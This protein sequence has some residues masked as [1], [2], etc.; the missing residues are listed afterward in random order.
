M[1]V[2]QEVSH[3]L[4]DG[5]RYPQA[6]TRLYGRDDVSEIEP[7]YLTTRWASLADH[8]PILVRLNGAGLLDELDAD[9]DLPRALS[10]LQSDA[11]S[12][13]LSD[14]LRHCLT[15]TVDGQY[16]K[17]LRFADPLVTRHWLASYGDAVPAALMGLITTWWV[18][19][20]PPNWEDASPLVWQ[21]FRPDDGPASSTAAPAPPFPPMGPAQLAALE[22]VERWRLKERLTNHFA[23]HAPKPWQALPPAERGDW[24]DARL[25]DAI[26][27]GATTERQIAIW[28]DLSLH[29]GANFMTAHDGLYARW[30]AEQ[31]PGARPPRPDSLYA[32]DTWWREGER[33]PGGIVTSPTVLSPSSSSEVPHG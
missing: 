28:V 14:Q 11:S 13:A 1:S 6:L 20:W 26:G 12:E 4:V 30:L 32:L 19:A 18:A 21:P 25:D 10:L 23:A 3:A 24:I 7:L 16:E 17:L 33:P 27:W 22:A 29:G 8:G 15:F 2:P 5:V 9:D 31:P